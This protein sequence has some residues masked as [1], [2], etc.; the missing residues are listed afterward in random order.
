ME[1]LCCVQTNSYVADTTVLK[2]YGS[3]LYCVVSSVC[4][5]ISD[6]RTATILN[7]TEFAEKNY[8]VMHWIGQ[9][10][11]NLPR[12]LTYF[13][14]LYQF[15][16]HFSQFIQAKDGNSTFLQNKSTKF[17]KKNQMMTN[18]ATSTTMKT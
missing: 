5:D 16:I 11:S 2:R 4:S 17:C 14:T 15:S 3:V 10:P 13:L 8:E 6:K 1:N 7:V 18:T 9:I 12:Q